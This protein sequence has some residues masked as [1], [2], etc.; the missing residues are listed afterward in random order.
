MNTAEK[1]LHDG[2]CADCTATPGECMKRKQCEGFQTGTRLIDLY[3]KNPHMLAQRL[4]N[5]V[6]TMEGWRYTDLTGKYYLTREDAETAV[7]KQLLSD[8][9]D[10]E[11]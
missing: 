3:F 6:T 5:I 4:V 2:W 7:Y 10:Y 1:M 11:P 9:E 8:P